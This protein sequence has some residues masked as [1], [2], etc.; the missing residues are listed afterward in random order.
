MTPCLLLF[1]NH[2]Q[3][4][5]RPASIVQDYDIGATIRNSTMISN[6][7][8][9]SRG[10]I[11]TDRVAKTYDLMYSQRAFVLWYVGEGMEEGE[12]GEARDDL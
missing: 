4:N 6:N 7:I 12:F 10:R 3:L 8:G 11:F 5:E 9:I 1:R 2:T